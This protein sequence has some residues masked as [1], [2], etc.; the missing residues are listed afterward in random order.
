M[1]RSVFWHLRGLMIIYRPSSIYLKLDFLN[2]H[3]C[4]IETF[5]KISFRT[6]FNLVLQRFWSRSKCLEK[7]IYQ[8]RLVFIKIYCSRKVTDNL[9]TRKGCC[10]S[11]AF[12]NL[13]KLIRETAYWFSS[14]LL[15]AR[16]YLGAVQFF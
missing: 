7:S 10:D 16:F 4:H 5:L 14:I 3:I 15:K 6:I 9:R 11:S 13:T 1:H 8:A 2:V 12:R